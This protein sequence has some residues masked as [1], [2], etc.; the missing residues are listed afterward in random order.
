M[1]ARP[2][3]KADRSTADERRETGRLDLPTVGS[4][5]GHA[6]PCARGPLRPARGLCA[7]A[8]TRLHARSKPRVRA[9]RIRSIEGASSPSVRTAFTGTVCLQSTTQKSCVS[10]ARGPS[11]AASSSSPSQWAFCRGKNVNK[12]TGLRIATA[13]RRTLRAISGLRRRRRLRPPGHR[14]E[15]ARPWPPQASWR[16]PALVAP[17]ARPT[18]AC[19]CYW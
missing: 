15:S 11:R 1:S 3:P 6:G 19:R 8:L 13:A 10:R 12:R 17:S 16:L 5:H 18:P 9:L 2:P 7:L 14:S 4:A